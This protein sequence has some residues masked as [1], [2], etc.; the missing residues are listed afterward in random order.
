MLGHWSIFLSPRHNFTEH[1]RALKQF[2][3]STRS[4]LS[5]H[6]GCGLTNEVM[7]LKLGHPKEAFQ[8]AMTETPS[9]PSLA[10]AAGNCLQAAQG[11]AE[12]R[13][14]HQFE[15]PVTSPCLLTS[16]S[17]HPEVHSLLHILP[18]LPLHNAEVET[19]T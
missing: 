12:P 16:L 14:D 18:L 2:S 10:D 5:S 17:V 7:S 9:P 4:G 6:K 15:L 8:I 11:R 19:R 1:K 13:Y 3:L